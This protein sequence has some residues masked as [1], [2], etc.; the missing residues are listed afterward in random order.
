[1]NDWISVKTPKILAD[2]FIMSAPSAST[3]CGVDRDISRVS[4]RHT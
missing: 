2:M 4:V 1:M 3:S